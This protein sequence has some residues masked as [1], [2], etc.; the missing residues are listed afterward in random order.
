M[1]KNTIKIVESGTAGQAIT[2]KARQE[3]LYTG[4]ICS[5]GEKEN[6]FAKI[7]KGSVYS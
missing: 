2:C 6:P 3:C 7:T 1:F 4:L 5:T